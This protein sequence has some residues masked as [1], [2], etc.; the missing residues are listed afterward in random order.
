MKRT[1]V[2]LFGLFAFLLL[3]VCASAFAQAPAIENEL[4]LNTPVSQDVHDPMLKAFAAWAKK[5]YNLHVK[6]SAIPK[7]TPVAYGQILDWKGKP[8]AGV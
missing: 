4:Y 2:L 1:G 8:A 6:T 7:G 5:K 3:T